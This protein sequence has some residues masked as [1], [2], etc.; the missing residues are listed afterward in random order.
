MHQI[1]AAGVA[2]VQSRAR[3]AA[4]GYLVFHI[5][6][7]E[8]EKYVDRLKSKQGDVSHQLMAFRKS[9]LFHSPMS[10][11]SAQIPGNGS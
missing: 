1:L 2:H 5:V 9:S 8:M 4:A 11:K 7:L 10:D 3:L 6:V